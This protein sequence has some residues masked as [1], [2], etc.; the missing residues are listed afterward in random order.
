MKRVLAMF[1]V[2]FAF[3]ISIG[4]TTASADRAVFA[5]GATVYQGFECQIGL[6]T[7]DNQ[8][9]LLTSTTSVTVVTESG[10]AVNHC[11]FTDTGYSPPDS[12]FPFFCN[13]QGAPAD[14]TELHISPSGV[15]SITCV[16]RPN[17]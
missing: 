13:V 9:V 11:T 17:H 7:P 2:V 5:S 10:A 6:P 1:G 3:A 16:V 15:V 4:V 12:S 8:G 14:V